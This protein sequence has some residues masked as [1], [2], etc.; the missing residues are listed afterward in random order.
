[1]TELNQHPVWR[2]AVRRSL[3]DAVFPDW[4]AQ[5]KCAE[6]KVRSGTGGQV[7]DD[8][9]KD[10]LSTRK[11]DAGEWPSKVVNAMRLCASCPVRRECLA[12]AVESEV[13]LSQEW[14]T[15]EVVA[16]DRRFGVYGGVPGRIRERM[17]TMRCPRCGGSGTQPGGFGE[18]PEGMNAKSWNKTFW[19]EMGPRLNK[20]RAG[21]PCRHCRGSGRLPHPERIER[22]ETYFADFARERRWSAETEEEGVA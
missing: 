13:R 11:A 4:T 22:C 3:D 19:E 18:P 21:W 9:F 12:Y 7:H 8:F 15:G 17:T 10:E 2:A 14:R 16:V 20:D 6:V 1:M 5:A